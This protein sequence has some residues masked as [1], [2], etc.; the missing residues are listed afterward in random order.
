MQTNK[1]GIV[2]Y[3]KPTS[4][5]TIIN[6]LSNRPIGHKM[7]AFKFHISGIHSLPL[8]QNKRQKEWEIIQ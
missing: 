4:T 1:T 5:G 3:R 7:A 2:I 6:F 8:D